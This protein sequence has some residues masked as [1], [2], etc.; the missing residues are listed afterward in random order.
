MSWEEYRLR[1]HQAEGRIVPISKEI[2]VSLSPRA[3]FAKIKDEPFSFLLE[4]GRTHEKIGRFSF[5]GRRP[6]LVFKSKG[7]SITIIQEGFS[8]TYEACP[9]EELRKAFAGYKSVKVQGLPS[10]TGG[11]L[12]YFGYDAGGLFEELPHR[13]FDDLALPDIFLIFVDTLAALDHISGKVHIISNI[14]PDTPFDDAYDEALGKIAAM[15]EIIMSEDKN[16]SSVVCGP[17]SVV[18]DFLKTVHGSQVTDYGA[19]IQP[20][21]PQRRY[22]DMVLRAKEYISAGDIYQANLSQRFSAKLPYEPFELYNFLTQI[23]PSCFAAYLNFGKLKVASS[24]PERLI[25]LEDSIAQTRPIAG[26]RPRGRDRAED[27][28]LKEELILNAK[29]RAEHIMLVDLERNDLGRVCEYG[30]V[31]VDELMVLE[32]YSHVTHIVSNVCGMLRRD[33]DR[34]DL[35]ASVFPGGTITGVPKIRCMEIIDELEPLARN[36]YT[37]SIGYLGFNGDMDMNIVIRTFVIKDDTAYVQVGAGIVADSD[38]A[39]EYYETLYKAEALF[40]SL[41][42]KDRLRINV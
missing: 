36:I 30:S 28:Q 6:Y 18:R 34:F 27:A 23:N 13:A 8:R 2:S 38:P 26:T 42:E 21:M 35:L 41:K 15:E 22:E 16:H 9:I 17:S 20:N 33:K 32:S 1:K 25:K 12:G 5:L 40:N 31:H 4:S 14:F 39:R 3:I 37:G 10:F 7:N 24:S 19:S 29:E 11:A